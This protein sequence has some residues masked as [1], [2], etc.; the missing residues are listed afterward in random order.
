MKSAILIFLLLT[1][2]FALSQKK[3]EC[4]ENT[5]ING[6]WVEVY[7]KKEIIKERKFNKKNNKRRLQGKSFQM[8]I[9]KKRTAREFFIPQDSIFNGK[10]FSQRLNLLSSKK[11]HYIYVHLKDVDHKLFG[12]IECLDTITSKLNEIKV[13]K[14]DFFITKK[15]SNKYCF[16]ITYVS[17]EWIHVK[18]KQ[19]EKWGFLNTDSAGML[20]LKLPF[21]DVFILVKIFESKTSPTI[22]DFRVNKWNN[23]D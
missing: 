16:K 12:K 9:D 8:M 5:K 1:T 22:Q 2:H 3:V 15:P 20:Y 23:V 19:E 11:T 4:I 17:G 18:V 21:L 7:T 6:Y 10:S 13:S 14:E